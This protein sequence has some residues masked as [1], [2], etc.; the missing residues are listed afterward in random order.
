[1]RP[2]FFRNLGNARFEEWRADRLGPFFDEKRSGRG[3]SRVDWNRDGRPDFAASNMSDP[4]SLVLNTTQQ[5]GNF[6]TLS[7]I[8]V[9]TA[10]DAIETNVE[11]RAG[12][13]RWR[14]QLTAG[15]GYM[16]SNERTLNFGLGK[17]DRVEE[18]IVEWPSGARTVAR[19]V[20]VNAALEIT[21]ERSHAI[22]RTGIDGACSFDVRPTTAAESVK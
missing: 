14:K 18:L 16:A 1:M 19:D 8:A 4:A 7:F 15:D 2:Q 11:V 20:P 9:R 21:E 17:A 13:R 10:R 6:L 5:P 3:L 12:T 22:L